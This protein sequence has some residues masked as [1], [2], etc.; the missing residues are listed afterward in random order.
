MKELISE[1][2]RALVDNPE[3]VTV[4]E[5]EGGQALILELKVAKEDMGKIIGIDLGT[6]NS[7]VSFVDLDAAAEGKPSIRIFKVPQPTGVGEVSRSPVFKR[8][9]PRP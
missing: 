2:A 7:A 1:I 9:E 3:Q 8:Q 6:T 4:N 5:V